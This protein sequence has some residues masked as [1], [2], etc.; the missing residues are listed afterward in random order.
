MTLTAAAT[1]VNWSETTLQRTDWRTFASPSVSKSPA[2][3]PPA[4][5]AFAQRMSFSAVKATVSFAAGSPSQELLPQLNLRAV[6]RPIQSLKQ[7]IGGL[8]RLRG[9]TC[10]PADVLLTQGARQAIDLICQKL[11]KPGSLVLTD[12]F[13]DPCLL[14]AV[15]AQGAVA[16]PMPL[17][18]ETSDIDLDRI[19]RTMAN[20]ARPAFIYLMPEGRNPVGVS[21][22]AEQRAGLRDLAREFQI[23]IVEDDSNGFLTHEGEAVPAMLASAQDTVLYIGCFSKILGASAGTGWMIVP[24]A[25]KLRFQTLDEVAPTAGQRMVASYLEQGTLEFHLAATRTAYRYRRCVMLETLE[26]TMPADVRFT[27]PTSGMFVWVELPKRF[28]AD[29]L[30]ETCTQRGVTFA[31]GREFSFQADT[32]NFI[33]LNFAGCP[34]KEIA[35][36]VRRL[37]SVLNQKVN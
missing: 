34:E 14:N 28:S 25:L 11:L 2:P 36:G 10:A 8:M 20:G 26:A 18:N 7:Q 3:R 22:S 9:V 1:E 12:K 17:M 15:R 13:T 19:R 30:L 29:S 6:E 37:A 16:V 5:N 4:S 35:S 21:M 31:A 24:K 27:R 23:L 33:R 32:R